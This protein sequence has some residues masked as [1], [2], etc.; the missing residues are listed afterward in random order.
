MEETSVIYSIGVL[1]ASLF[2]VE[3]IH[4]AFEN[5]GGAD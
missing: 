2:T 1:T 4:G 3:Y 5:V